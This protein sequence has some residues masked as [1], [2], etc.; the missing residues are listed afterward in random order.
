M[1]KESIA[2]RAWITAICHDH[3]G[4][5]LPSRAY[6]RDALTKHSSRDFCVMALNLMVYPAFGRPYAFIIS[7]IFV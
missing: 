6:A 1:K 3:I 2:W 4:L 5:G 7:L